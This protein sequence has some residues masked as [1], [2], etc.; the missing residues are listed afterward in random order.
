MKKQKQN[1]AKLKQLILMLGESC[2]NIEWSKLNNLLYKIDM[3]AYAQ[4]GNS[5]TG[6]TYVHVESGFMVKNFDTIL[7]EM[8]AEGRIHL[9]FVEKEKPKKAKKNLPSK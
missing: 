9:E 1:K 3:E 4:L 7:D 8:M 6:S 2:T 5:I